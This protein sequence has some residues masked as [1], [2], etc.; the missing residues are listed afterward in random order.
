MVALSAVNKL[1]CSGGSCDTN[2]T[3]V[4]GNLDG[5]VNYISLSPDGEL[6]AIIIG[7]GQILVMTHDWDLLYETPLVDDDD[8]PQGHHGHCL[9]LRK[10]KTFAGAVLEW[11]PS[12]ANIAAVYDR[13]AEDECPSIVFFER[14]GLERSKFS[15]G[16]RV[17]TKVRF[18]KW[19]CSSDL[20]AG[21]VECENYDAMKIWY[22]SN[23]HWYVKHEIRYLKKD[24]VRFIWNQEKLLQ[25]I[26]WTLGGQVTI[27]NF[28]WITAVTDNSAAL[29]IDGSNIHVTPLS[30]SFMPPPMY[31]VSLKCSSHVRGTTVYC[32]NS[33]N[34]LAAILSD[35]SLCVGSVL[36]QLLNDT[37]GLDKTA[38]LELYSHLE[39]LAEELLEAY[40]GV[41][42]A[43]IEH[44]EG[45]RGLLNEY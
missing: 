4:I 23:N 3:Q 1:C 34:K 16:E 10:K 29:V 28:V 25:L 15:V 8:V 19:N 5:G 40:S 21:V 31:L 20:L 35:G 17:N 6:L 14:N 32:K 37:F 42:T 41:V 22:F 30:L 36:L 9:L 39:A 11:M 26:C 24:E 33:K 2:A 12:G 13:K 43:K 18:L 7:F 45:H 38:D 27:Y 44:E